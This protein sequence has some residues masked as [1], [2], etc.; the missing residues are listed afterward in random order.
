MRFRGDQEVVL[1]VQAADGDA[2]G[3]TTRVRAILGILWTG[4]YAE[5]RL[6]RPTTQEG[7]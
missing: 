6:Y 2:V 1:D 7:L 3:S 4:D 5:L